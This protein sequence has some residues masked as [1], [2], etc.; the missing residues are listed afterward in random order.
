MILTITDLNKSILDKQLYSDLNISIEKGEKSALIGQNGTGKSTLFRIIMGQDTDYTGAIQFPN[1]IRIVATE[2]EHLKNSLISSKS[3]MEYILETIPY[4]NKW[5]AVLKQ[6]NDGKTLPDNYIE[7]LSDY[8]DAGY[9]TLEEEI[10]STLEGF[11]VSMEKSLIPLSN[12]SGGEKRFVE[13]TRVIYS[14]A[15]LILIDEPTNHL[16]TVGKETF[17]NWLSKTDKTVITISHDRDLLSVVNK[18]YELKGGKITE[19][20][21]NYQDY[22][23]QNL[24]STISDLNKYQTDIAR[25]EQLKKQADDAYLKKLTAKSDKGRLRSKILEERLKREYKKISQELV[26]PSFWLD[27]KSSTMINK[28][29]QQSYSKYK[30]KTIKIGSVCNNKKKGYQKQLF[31]IKELI[32]GYDTDLFNPI[33]FDFYTAQ[34]VHITGRNGA[35]KSSFIKY[36]I[37]EITNTYP[38]EN[39]MLISSTSTKENMCQ[40]LNGEITI[41]NAIKLGVYEQE[42]SNDY[43][44][45]TLPKAIGKVL[46]ENGLDVNN[47]VV[48]QLR[49]QYLF[50]SRSYDSSLLCELSGGEKARFQMMK[51]FMNNPNLLIL[52]EPTNHLD[53]PSIE[54]LE[55]FLSAYTGGVLFVS[56]DSFFT[57]SV[58]PNNVII[59]EK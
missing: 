28:K 6:A 27:E 31:Q 4:Y 34:K 40:L 53:L 12:L 2:Q 55:K 24:H 52:D 36:L 57:K 37:K 19:Y 20:K 41:K 43:L 7:V 18:I 35:G 9:F 13:I 25:I 58:N 46:A 48:F 17:I 32:L 5:Q 49:N 30:D 1:G 3:A 56:H 22:L 44:S 26:K 45:L 8:T 10:I 16:D 51:L 39:K 14:K 47:T 38:D 15:D 23:R 33:S 11:G 42:I 29:V 50:D 21:G 54:V 59:V